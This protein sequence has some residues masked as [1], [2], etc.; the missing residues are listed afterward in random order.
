MIQNTG[1]DD[2]VRPVL[3][4]TKPTINCNNLKINAT[5][6]SDEHSTYDRRIYFVIVKTF[7]RRT[8]ARANIIVVT[9]ARDAL[10]T[11]SSKSVCRQDANRKAFNAITIKYDFHEVRRWR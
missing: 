10:R 8:R 3:E 7:I 6:T 9:C 11:E 5:Y 2:G 4:N 1:M